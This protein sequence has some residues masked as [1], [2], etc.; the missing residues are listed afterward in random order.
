MKILMV[1]IPSLHF[2][3]WTSQL[4]NAGHEVYWFDITG[5]GGENEKL[6][7][8]SQKTNWKLRWDFRGRTFI[9]NKFP[10][11]YNMIQKHNENNTSSVFESC[12]K[13]IQPDLVHSFALQLSCLPILDVMN[14]HKNL[15]WTFSSWGSDIFYSSEI[16]IDEVLLRECF[17]RI[18][19]LITDCKRDYKFAVLKGFKNSFLGVLPGNGGVDFCKN[20]IEAFNERKIILIKGYNDEIG[21]GINIIK[22]FDDEL[23]SLLKEYEVIIF[24]ADETIRKYIAENIKLKNLKLTLHLKS[25]FISNDYLISLMGKTYIYI[26][27]SLSD[28]IPNALIEAMGMGAFPIQSNPGNVTEEIIENGI[29]GLLINNPNDV[30]G[31]KKLI[32]RSLNDKKMIADALLFNKENVRNKYDRIKTREKILNIYEEIAEKIHK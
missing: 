13:E 31:I 27:N 8:V 4:E 17:K 9:K 15:K 20:E 2:F 29:N 26:A 3:R 21:R 30:Y 7:W 6:N 12:L 23:I 14:R 22:A 28:G 25:N 24:G 19:Y 5:M 18:D 32:I 16:G 10:F 11:V 1:S